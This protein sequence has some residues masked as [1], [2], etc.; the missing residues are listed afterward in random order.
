MPF[1]SRIGDQPHRDSPFND[2][3]A[4]DGI[5]PDLTANDRHVAPPRASVE[6]GEQLGMFD[7]DSG[8]ST[9]APRYALIAARDKEIAQSPP[10]TLAG[11]DDRMIR[12]SR[13]MG[14]RRSPF[15]GCW[16]GVRRSTSQVPVTNTRQS[17]SDGGASARWHSRR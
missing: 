16:R 13:P 15:A 12:W 11:E 4:N 9:E 5:A 1:C 14:R 7:D 3:A 8:K 17:R 2:G 10:F 6:L